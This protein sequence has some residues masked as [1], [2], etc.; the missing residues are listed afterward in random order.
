MNKSGIS[1]GVKLGWK[2][3]KHITNKNKWC[4]SVSKFKIYEY[5]PV[6]FLLL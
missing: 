6:W 1:S 3:L 4:L 5:V 2:S